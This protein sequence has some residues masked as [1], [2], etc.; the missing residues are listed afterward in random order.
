[1]TEKNANGRTV[2]DD[3]RDDVDGRANAASRYNRTYCTDDS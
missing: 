1:M 2:A 3:K